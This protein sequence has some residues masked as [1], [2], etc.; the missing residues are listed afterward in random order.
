MRSPCSA[1]ILRCLGDRLF[2]RRQRRLRG[3]LA[4]GRLFARGERR[5]EFALGVALV[6]GERGFLS[7]DRAQRLGQLRDLLRESRFRFAGERQLLLEPRHLG[8][9]GVKPALLFVQRVAGGVVIGPQRLELSL[10]GAQFRLQRLERD[11]QR[12]HFRRAFVADAN[13]V[14]LLREPHEVLRLLEAPFQ[15]AI[16]GRDPCLRREALEL[17]AQLQPDVLD[18]RQVLARVREAP[19]GLLAP[20]LVLR[21][22]GGFF[23]E[24]AQLLGLGL[25]DAGNHPLLDDRVGARAQARAEEQ[26]V[27]VAAADGNVVDVVRR[28]AVARQHALDG[29]FRVLAP[30]AAD[31]A[32]AVVEMQFDRRA[33][34]R[35]A[36]AGAVEDHVL[37]RL[38]A[39]R[40][41]LRLAQHP[42]HGVDDIRLAAAVG[43]DDADQ[44]AG[45]GDGGRV[46]E[47]LEPGELDLREAQGRFAGLPRT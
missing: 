9:G 39:Q 4:L 11:G 24:D 40:R 27:D 42:A 46:D 8:I 35:L 29:D 14:L 3:K 12:R 6:G 33:A 10:R 38:A 34:H 37:H 44:L 13:G 30:L 36:F 32:L 7:G 20:L 5:F 23:E 26:V 45:R 21:H 47:R 28:V 19:F 1:R 17:V 16:F 41:C 43:P 18:A 2:Q 15:L 22:A 25:D 31:A